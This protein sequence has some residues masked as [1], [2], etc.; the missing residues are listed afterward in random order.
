MQRWPRANQAD[1]SHLGPDQYV[2]SERAEDQSAMRAHGAQQLGRHDRPSAPDAIEERR[3][4]AAV[5]QGRQAP[6]RYQLR[7]R[8]PQAPFRLPGGLRGNRGSRR[9]GFGFHF[10]LDLSWSSSEEERVVQE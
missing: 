7:H 8:Q 1:E 4:G 10:L 9:R 2:T 6:D 3:S 5:L